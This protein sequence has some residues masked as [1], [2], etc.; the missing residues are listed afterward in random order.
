MPHGGNSHQ[1]RKTRRWE[2]SRTGTWRVRAEQLFGYVPRSA[3]EVAILEG[4]A[5]CAMAADAFEIRYVNRVPTHRR[6]GPMMSAFEEATLSA[7][8][9]DPHL[10]VKTVLAEKETEDE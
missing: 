1:R 2:A 8:A 7:M 9:D 5:W 4:R 6:E 3:T 10:F